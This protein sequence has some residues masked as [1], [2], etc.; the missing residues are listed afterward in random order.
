MLRGMQKKR[1]EEKK[2]DRRYGERNEKG[3]PARQPVSQIKNIITYR[4][5]H[6]SGGTGRGFEMILDAVWKVFPD[7]ND[8]NAE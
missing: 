1:K 8:D 2:D 7:G 5:Y 3:R 6:R 4:L